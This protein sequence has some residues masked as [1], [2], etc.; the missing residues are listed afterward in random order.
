[1][2]LIAH[3]KMYLWFASLLFVI[4]PVSSFRVYPS[5][6]GRLEGRQN[7]DLVVSLLQSVQNNEWRERKTDLFE[8]RVY[9]LARRSCSSCQ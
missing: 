2:N 3:I 9:W 4:S 5:I 1:M 6:Y 7:D 8:A